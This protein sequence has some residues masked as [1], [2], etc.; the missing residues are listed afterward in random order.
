M[1][2]FHG[3]EG[4][5]KLRSRGADVKPG[6]T[7]GP[8]LCQSSRFSSRLRGG[9]IPAH[10]SDPGVGAEARSVEAQ[11]LFGTATNG[12]HP[13]GAQVQAPQLAFERLAR[14]KCRAG[15]EGDVRP[16][17]GVAR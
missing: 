9:P 16:T 15:K 13:G 14:S 6:P 2:L 17:R 3:V 12:S 10:G 4:V 1:G 5:D 8:F 11:A 7:P